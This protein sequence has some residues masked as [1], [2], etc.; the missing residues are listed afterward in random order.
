M[1]FVQLQQPRGVAVGVAV[2]VNVWR[3]H[4]LPSQTPLGTNDP[5]LSGP[6]FVQ[7]D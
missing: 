5:Q 7:E 6:L 4:A 3:T 1:L 2:G